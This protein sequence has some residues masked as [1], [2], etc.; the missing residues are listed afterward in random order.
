M[1]HTQQDC[2]KTSRW[3]K[4]KQPD[5]GQ[6][7]DVQPKR[8]RVNR[9][10]LFPQ[11]KSQLS[12]VGKENTKT[13]SPASEEVKEI[14]SPSGV[15]PG[16]KRESSGSV[17]SVDAEQP[18]CRSV[19][20][21]E[22][23][24]DPEMPQS[25]GECTV[26]PA[27]ESPASEEVKEIPSP[28]GV[29]PGLIMESSGS[30]CSVDAEQPPCRSVELVESSSDPEM[31][32]SSGECT[33]HLKEIIT[34]SDVRSALKR[35]RTGS[36]AEQPPCKRLKKE[37]KLQSCTVL[38]ADD[39]EMEL[40]VKALEELRLEDSVETHLETAESP[41][42]EELEG[43]TAPSDVR[44]G[45]KRKRSGSDAEQ[46]PCKRFKKEEKPQSCTV[47]PADGSPASEGMTQTPS[48]VKARSGRK[49]K[50]PLSPCSSF[51][52]PCK[53]AKR[54][55]CLAPRRQHPTIFQT[56]RPSALIKIYL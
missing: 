11:A 5:N 16:L 14:Q 56:P 17:C 41:S 47:L 26:L 37:E 19:E 55:P 45:L 35:K 3:S 28:S 49:R 6:N 13:E 36:D 15:S 23:S 25:S 22:S 44:S 27:E 38:P 8:L 18:P 54:Q 4:K 31:P 10:H 32:Q 40:L 1:S 52:S 30:V 12:D 39:D 24:S 34:P 9:S 21:V 33:V 46:P 50:A 29:S 51:E 48:A 2:R 42:S 53:R 43:V 7:Q 20:L